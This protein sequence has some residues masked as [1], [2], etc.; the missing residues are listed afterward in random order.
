[1]NVD[2]THYFHRDWVSAS[3]I[4]RTMY[5][6]VLAL[7]GVALVRAWRLSRLVR[8]R[9]AAAL[10]EPLARAEGHLARLRGLLCLML[11]VTVLAALAASAGS[12]FAYVSA[13][14]GQA[15]LEASQDAAVRLALMLPMSLVVCALWVALDAAVHRHVTRL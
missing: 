5:V 11:L 10:P 1:M 13:P 7:F 4:E 12:F 2:L 14:D 8:T 9:S 6:A 3:P 15:M